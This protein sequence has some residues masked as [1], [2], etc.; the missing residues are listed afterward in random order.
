MAPSYCMSGSG[1]SDPAEVR[2]VDGVQFAILWSGDEYS[3]NHTW[4]TAD[5]PTVIDLEEH[6]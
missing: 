6:R 4:I 1:N 5:E 2:V 3:F